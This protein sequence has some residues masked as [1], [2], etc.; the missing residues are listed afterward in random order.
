MHGA[1]IRDI[2]NSAGGTESKRE[3]LERIT[4]IADIESLK[5]GEP[6]NLK[7]RAGRQVDI[8]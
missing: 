7:Q 5:G 8:E 3:I 1:A 4:H 2:G 6:G